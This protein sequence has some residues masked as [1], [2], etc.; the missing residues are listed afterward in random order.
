MANGILVDHFMMVKTARL[1]IMDDYDIRFELVL[2]I[3]HFTDMLA[4]LR[5]NL[6]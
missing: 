6:I 1:I 3:N 4:F 2:E 5:N